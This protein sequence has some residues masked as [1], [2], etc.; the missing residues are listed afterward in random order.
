VFKPAVS[1]TKTPE[2]YYSHELFVNMTISGSLDK[3]IFSAMYC[4]DLVLMCNTFLKDI[5]PDEFIFETGNV[6]DL[7]SKIRYILD[8]SPQAKKDITDKMKKYVQDNHGVPY[9]VNLLKT[10]LFSLK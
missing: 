1:N 10:D 6:V 2:V 3:T 7:A 9:L 5:L 8:M 4:R